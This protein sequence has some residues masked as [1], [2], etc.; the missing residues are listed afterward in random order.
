ML[1][2]VIVMVVAVVVIFPV[3]LVVVFVN[4]RFVGTGFAFLLQQVFEFERV[5]PSG[6]MT[7]LP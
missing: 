3:V 4:H 2:F 5:I 1:L 7:E 6:K